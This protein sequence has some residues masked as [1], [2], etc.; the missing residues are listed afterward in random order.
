MRERDCTHHAH[1]RIGTRDD[2]TAE[3]LL[4]GTIVTKVNKVDKHSEEERSSHQEYGT[5]HD[6]SLPARVCVRTNWVE[7]EE[8][9]AA[10]WRK[11]TTLTLLRKENCRHCLVSET[12]CTALKKKT[13]KKPRPAAVKHTPT[14]PNRSTSF[15][16]AQKHTIVGR[17]SRESACWSGFSREGILILK[18]KTGGRLGNHTS[19]RAPNVS[20]PSGA[21]CP[22]P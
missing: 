2:H 15:L 21:C 7:E 13:K 8:E 18:K 1:A 6:S 3:G 22:C 10:V 11:R 9:A 5:Q 4:P 16:R 17:S 12:D 14:T 20:A 19:S